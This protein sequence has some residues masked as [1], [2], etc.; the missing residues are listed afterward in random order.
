MGTHLCGLLREKQKY[1]DEP[2]DKVAMPTGRREA[3][4]HIERE[5]FTCVACEK[6]SKRVHVRIRNAKL[7]L[8]CAR[9]VYR[10]L[11]REVIRDTQ[12]GNNLQTQG[13]KGR[14]MT[15]KPQVDDHAEYQLHE[16]R[17]RASEDSWGDDNE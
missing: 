8:P 6:T 15:K 17:D 10:R 2:A 11:N 5:Q 4:I 9:A 1:V 13:W 3:K 7:C 14:L 12:I 16:G